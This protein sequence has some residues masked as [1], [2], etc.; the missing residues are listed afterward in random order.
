MKIRLLLVA[1]FFSVLSFGQTPN[2]VIKLAGPTVDFGQPI[3]MGTILVDMT[4]N[5][6][7]LAL[8]SLPG[9]LKLNDCFPFVALGPGVKSV[10][11]ISN[12]T[13]TGGDVNGT[14]NSDVLTIG[15]GK[16]TSDMI[17]NGTI[18]TADI[19]DYQVTLNK[20]ATIPTS[21]ILGNSTGVDAVPEPIL[22]SGGLTMTGGVLS[23]SGG[24]IQNVTTATSNGISAPVT[25]PSPSNALITLSAANLNNTSVTSTGLIKGNVLQSTV[26]TGTAPFLVTST[27]PV[28]NLNIAGNAGTA[29]VASLAND[30]SGG[31]EGSIPYQTGADATS[32]LSVG[33]V[34]QILQINAAGNAPEWTTLTSIPKAV[35]ILDNTQSSITWNVVQDGSNATINLTRNT[36][37]QITGPAIGTS[38]NLTVTNT[39]TYTLRLD[40][41]SAGKV[42]RYSP[43]IWMAPADSRNVQVTSNSSAGPTPDLYSWYYDGTV[44]FWSGKLAYK[45]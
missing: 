17:L 2:Q 18:A 13:H 39:G 38:G 4:N 8:E 42:V 26:L 20:M 10:K 45:K 5:K 35:K 12:S 41:V 31:L 32:W 29:S 40:Y 21:Y 44:L 1:I 28:Q 6:E 9:N 37:I 34:G 15:S 27:T 23:S 22:I 16:V 11:E 14:P 7:W 30:M 25:Y 19:G 3:P 36:Y 43:D 24:T 33:T